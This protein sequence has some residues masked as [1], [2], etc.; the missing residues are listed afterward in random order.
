MAWW[1]VETVTE[2]SGEPSSAASGY[3]NS[4][5]VAAIIPTAFYDTANSRDEWH[6]AVVGAGIPADLYIS[7]SYLTITD[8]RSAAQDWT[9]AR[10]D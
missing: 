5:Q 4:N 8:A 3:V 6:N 7:G 1:N 9:G 10:N 2:V